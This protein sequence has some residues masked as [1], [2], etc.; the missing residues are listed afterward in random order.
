M[1]TSLKILCKTKIQK[2]IAKR[3]KF[4]EKKLS[5]TPKTIKNLLVCRQGFVEEVFF[6]FDS[7]QEQPPSKVFFKE[8]NFSV[9]AYLR[10]W[11]KS[12][13]LEFYDNFPIEFTGISK[14]N[15]LDF[16]NAFYRI[17]N[18]IFEQTYVQKECH[19]IKF[20]TQCS[21]N[22]K[23]TIL[24]AFTHFFHYYYLASRVEAIV[25]FQ[26]GKFLSYFDLF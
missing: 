8:I 13:F 26:M 6:D 9:L 24:D 20:S 11:D 14:S 22:C 18:E 21:V 16:L 3:P 1:T 25:S 23:Y 12:F 10:R 15:C 19:T 7:F 17:A 2:N 5:K 4:W